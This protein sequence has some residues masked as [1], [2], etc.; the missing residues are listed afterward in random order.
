MED[1]KEVHQIAEVDN[2]SGSQEEMKLEP[3]SGSKI[4]EPL[5]Q[6]VDEILQTNEDQIFDIDDVNEEEIVNKNLG[7]AYS[8]H[9][10][11]NNLKDID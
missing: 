7:G 3:S 9:A 2:E 6:D 1:Y 5:V 4:H 10:K 11:T 8:L